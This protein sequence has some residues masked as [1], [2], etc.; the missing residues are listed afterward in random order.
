MRWL[1]IILVLIFLTVPGYFIQAW[2]TN[3]DLNPSLV[4]LALIVLVKAASIVYP[5]LPGIILTLAM[6]PVLGWQ[7]AYMVE[8]IGSLLGVTVA[9]WLGFRFGE[10]IIRWIAGEKLL[11]KIKAVKLKSG[12]QF[13]AAFV[14]RTASGGALSD[15][16]A[17]GA[18]LIG[19]RYWPYLLGHLANHV[20][21]TLPLFVLVGWSVKLN[22]W[23]LIG[24]V[25]LIAWLLVWKFKG[26]Y[27]E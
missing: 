9:Y 26:R 2:Y 16:L 20:L 17:W 14:L 19:L 11:T 12:N 10:K 4:T 3:L 5:P 21:A 8:L 23:L 6:V 7:K 22:S 27:F 25:M 15:T 13:E 1:K 24:P 18:S